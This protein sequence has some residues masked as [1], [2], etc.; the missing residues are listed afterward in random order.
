MWTASL[1]DAAQ[2]MIAELTEAMIEGGNATPWRAGVIKTAFPGD[3]AEPQVRRLFDAATEASRQTQAALIVHTEQG[4]GVERLAEYLVEQ[5]IEPERV[6]LCHLDKRPDAGLHRSL[7]RGGFLLEYDTFARPKYSP[8]K[9]VWP[10]VECLL[11][12]GLSSSIACGLDLADSSQWAF[13]GGPGMLFFTECVQPRLRSFGASD[14]VV[15]ALLGQNIWERVA[16]RNVA[17]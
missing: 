3:W 11:G 16:M 13:G 1:D 15:R 17:G 7:A 8:E 10:L 6:V 2:Y 12:D 4:A 9:N 5:S 14:T